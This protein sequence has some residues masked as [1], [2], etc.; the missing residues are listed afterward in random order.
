MAAYQVGKIMLLIKKP[1]L[2]HIRSLKPLY[3]L[4]KKIVYC[5][6]CTYTNQ[7]PNSEKEYKHKITTQKPTLKIDQTGICDACK[8]EV[9]GVLPLFCCVDIL[10]NQTLFFY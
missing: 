7:K 8:I 10:Y 9:N 6:L 1:K 5:K 3:G 2:K 4:P